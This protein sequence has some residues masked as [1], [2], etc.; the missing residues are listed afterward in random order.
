MYK[1][2]FYGT[3]SAG[4]RTAAALILFVV[5]AAASS[6]GLRNGIGILFCTRF[7]P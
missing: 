7:Y 5:A 3:A 4:V 1:Y 6:K 2:L